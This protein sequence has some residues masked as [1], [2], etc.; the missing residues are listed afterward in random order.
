MLVLALKRGGR[1][2][3]VSNIPSVLESVDPV[4]RHSRSAQEVGH[5]GGGQAP[6]SHGG[7][8][9]ARGGSR[10]LPC[11]LPKEFVTQWLRQQ[12]TAHAKR[13]CEEIRGRQLL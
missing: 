11:V 6:S 13:A 1:T 4:M 12:A 10:R 5:A 2:S 3:K 8:P 7:M 9:V